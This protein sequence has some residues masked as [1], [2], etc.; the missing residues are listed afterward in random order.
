M[1]FH[2]I[3][4]SHIRCIIAGSDVSKGSVLVFI[5][6]AELNGDEFGLPDF[7]FR[8]DPSYMTV[9]PQNVIPA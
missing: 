8:N 2:R 9:S 7:E 6:N 3:T 1:F 5:D 4:S